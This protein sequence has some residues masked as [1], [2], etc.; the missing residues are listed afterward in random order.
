MFPS[1]VDRILAYTVKFCSYESAGF[2]LIDQA[3]KK[4]VVCVS[5]GL[6]REGDNNIS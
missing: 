3:K 5:Y 6:Q 2:L 1:E 4:K